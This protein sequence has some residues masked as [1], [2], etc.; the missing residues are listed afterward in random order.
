LPGSPPAGVSSGTADAHGTIP[1]RSFAASAASAAASHSLGD[2]ASRTACRAAQASFGSILSG[3][4]SVDDADDF[5]CHRRVVIWRMASGDRPRTCP[6]L[7]NSA[8]TAQDSD[9]RS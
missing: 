2:F 9:P 7:M 8:S 4:A 5:V 6:A 1:A 3:N